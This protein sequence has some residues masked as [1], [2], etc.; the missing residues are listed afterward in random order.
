MIGFIILRHIKT[1][2]HNEI[3]QECYNCIRRFYPK[4][5]III[6]DDNSYNGFISELIDDNLEI[7][8]SEYP[9]KGELLPYYYYL[10]NYKKFDTA[11]I[12]HDSTFI[13]RYV[14]FTKEVNQCLW[15]FKSYKGKTKMSES[16]E[17]NMINNLSNSEKLLKLY[18]NKNEWNGC[19]GSMS[20]IQIDFLKMINNKYNILNL[21]PLI[22]TRNDRMRLERIFGLIMTYENNKRT[23]LFGDIHGSFKY[24]YSTRDSTWVLYNFQKYKNDKLH[25]L[26]E[27]SIQVFDP[28]YKP[29]YILPK[30]NIIKVLTGR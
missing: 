28:S 27:E 24:N 19:F 4:H 21:L 2:L 5:P 12:L 15:S 18:S 8:N 3:W 17:K 30:V 26:K 13:N 25:D 10:K 23:S 29:N 14:D 11:V 6:I 9:G 22:K 7:I 16:E 20:V 1:I